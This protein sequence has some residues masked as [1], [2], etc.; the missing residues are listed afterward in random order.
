MSQQ[1]KSGSGTGAQSGIDDDAAKSKRPK[2]TL[3][4]AAKDVTKEEAKAAS[5]TGATGDVKP[6]DLRTKPKLR[7]E[8]KPDADGPSST[9]GKS[10]T[11]DAGLHTSKK[12][13]KPSASEDNDSAFGSALTHLGAGVAGGLV[14]L[15]CAAYGLNWVDMGGPLAEQDRAQFDRRLEAVEVASKKTPSKVKDA[16]AK[17][18]ADIRKELA[19]AKSQLADTARVQTALQGRADKA[20]EAL[21][22]AGSAGSAGSSDSGESDTRLA[23]LEQAV[24]T[25]AAAPVTDGDSADAVVGVSQIQA[26]EV[27]VDEKLNAL[28]KDLTLSMESSAKAAG[29]ENVERDVLDVKDRAERVEKELLEVKSKSRLADEDIKTI[30]GEAL[31]LGGA[32]SELK[33]KVER[34]SAKAEKADQVSRDVKPL[35]GRIASLEEKLSGILERE[36]TVQT[37]ARKT[38]LAIALTN[39]KSAVD[40]GDAYA[41]ELETVQK[42]AP[43]GLKFEK[44]KAHASTGVRTRLKLERSFR[45]ASRRT[46]DA[47]ATPSENS[48]IGSLIANARSVVR[49]RR[50]GEVQGDTAEAVIARMEM[51]VKEGNLGAALKEADGLSGLAR[52][53][54]SP[55]VGHVSARLEVNA[56]MQRVETELIAAL[57]GVD[58]LD[59]ESQRQ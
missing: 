58:L 54:A 9:E 17:D 5:A 46:L 14:A 43:S 40:R 41:H 38:A 6:A 19:A 11:P 48:L 29:S 56:A 33:L 32:L 39:L 21:A 50:T 30:R 7:T 35:P 42:L 36:S 2:A 34:V 31:A 51:R 20:E 23:E 3:D 16:V 8:K 53:A 59:A 26:L 22:K 10:K 57:G 1:S 18:I 12:I 28:Q 55:W 24:K 13:F 47:D 4:L 45:D 44:L 52:E 37:D 49:V 25:L 15:F 27:R